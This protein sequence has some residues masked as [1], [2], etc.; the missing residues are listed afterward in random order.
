MTKRYLVAQQARD[1][2]LGDMI[3]GWAFEVM[4]KGDRTIPKSQRILDVKEK[5]GSVVVITAD[6]EYK[7]FPEHAVI[8]EVLA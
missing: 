8:V 4:V 2:K 6:T 1:L 3:A 7:F 5:N